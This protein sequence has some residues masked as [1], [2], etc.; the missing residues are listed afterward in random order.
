MRMLGWRWPLTKPEAALVG[1]TMLWG[2]TFLVVHLAVSHTGPWFFVGMR[3]LVAGLCC[4]LVFRRTL[5]SITRREVVVGSGIGFMIFLGY[6]LQTDGLRTISSSESA[7][8]TALYVP[9][10]PLLQWIV[11]RKA[12]GRA[13]LLGA[14][15]AFV[16]LTLLAG[17]N[18]FTIGLGPGQIATLVSTIAIAGEIVLIGRFAGRVDA[19]RVTVVQLLVGGSLATVAMPVVG[20]SVPPFSWAWVAPAIALGVASCLIQLTMNWAQRSVSPTRATIIYAG[21]PVWAGV[22]G[23][24]AGDAMPATTLLGAV[25][26]VCG[27]I[28]SELKPGRG[29][30]LSERKTAEVLPVTGRDEK[31][32]SA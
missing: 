31:Q 5:R 30:A 24:I 16:G 1:I 21:E 23:R 6:G 10:V 11:F 19:G 15:L 18:A 27:V 14:G 20:E 32:H 25:F 22:V 13:A 4:A 8:I 26:I 17:P 28:V 2:G 12:P 9:L 3:F 7:F 29:R